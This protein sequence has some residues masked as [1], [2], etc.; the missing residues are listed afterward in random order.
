VKLATLAAHVTWFG[1]PGLFH[2]FFCRSF[3]TH[4]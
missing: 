2:I 3:G 4:V 1:L